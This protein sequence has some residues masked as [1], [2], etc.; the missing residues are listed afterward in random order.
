M[1][2]RKIL[3]MSCLLLPIMACAHNL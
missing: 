3:A 1:T 2:L